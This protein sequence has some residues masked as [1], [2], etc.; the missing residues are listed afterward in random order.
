[1]NSY[2]ATYEKYLQQIE[3]SF[4]KYLPVASV[5]PAI[6]HE[7]MN[8]SMK[9]GGKRLRPVLVCAAFDVFGGE[10]DPIPAALAVECIHT[11]SLIHDDLPC[12]DNSNLRRG[13]PTCHVKFDESTALLAGDALLTYSF[14]LI[15][16][17]Y[18]KSPAIAVSL[19]KELSTAAG[20]EQLIGGQVEDTIQ[21]SEQMDAET[22]NFIHLNKTSAMIRVSLVMGFILAGQTDL[23]KAA[24]IGENIGM[25]FQYIDDILDV[26]QDTETLGKPAGLDIDNDKLTAVTLFGIDGAKEKARSFTDQ[27]ITQLRSLD[28]NT[29]FLELLA[30]K[31]L[32]RVS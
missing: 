25:A 11:Y 12:M 22:L 5:R 20:S 14:Q 31:F 15:S 32:E 27:A 18:Q 7:A 16:E 8:Y 26:I 19:L 29:Q 28:A 17:H 3:K 30:E 1:M 23:K 24:Q 9:V 6:L 21:S 2:T 4:E 13:Q 10:L